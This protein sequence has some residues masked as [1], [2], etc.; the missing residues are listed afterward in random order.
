MEK[1]IYCKKIV[2]AT[3]TDKWASVHFS[4]KKQ[5]SE[6]IRLLEKLKSSDID[7]IH[8]QD[9]KDNVASS[10]IAFHFPPALKRQWPHYFE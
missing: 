4:S 9:I 10:E 6:L 7:H 3:K 5:I 8:L 1:P 2:L